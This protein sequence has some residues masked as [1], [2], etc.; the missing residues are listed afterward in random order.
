MMAFVFVPEG[1]ET[2]CM[3]G[4]IQGQDHGHQGEGDEGRDENSTV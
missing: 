2:L 3:G 1:A 4:V